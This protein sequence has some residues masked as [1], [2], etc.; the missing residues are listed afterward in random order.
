MQEFLAALLYGWVPPPLD[1]WRNLLSTPP[2]PSLLYTSA[3]GKK[4][5]KM[6][7]VKCILAE[8]NE[9]GEAYHWWRWQ[10]ELWLEGWLEESR[11]TTS[12][13]PH[14]CFGRWWSSEHLDREDTQRK[15]RGKYWCVLISVHE[16]LLG[17]SIELKRSKFPI[18]ISKIDC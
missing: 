1:F 11:R 18:N 17:S 7:S 8:L 12:R 5:E 4:C 14:R 16:C 6:Y 3:V 2:T 15:L 9:R 10:G 13:R